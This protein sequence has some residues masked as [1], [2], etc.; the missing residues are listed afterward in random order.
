MKHLEASST[1]KGLFHVA[2]KVLLRD[3]D[4]V[5]LLH[6]IFNDWDLPGGRILPTE[7]GSDIEGVIKRKMSEELGKD[8]SYGIA[9]ISTYFQVTRT[10][11]DTGE[12][13]QISAVGF[14]ASY[15]GG[16]I[17]L[18]DN[19]DQYRWV[20]LHSLNPTDYFKHGWEDGVSRYIESQQ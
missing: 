5:L 19:H 15:L 9:E 1:D 14:T 18:G 3:G 11:H 2:I 7:F 17:K 4:R 20:D 13:S 6:D 10:E 16:T 8:V 12:Q